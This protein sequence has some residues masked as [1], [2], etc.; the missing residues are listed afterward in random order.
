MVLHNRYDT[1]IV[2]HNYPSLILSKIL[3]KNHPELLMIDDE[4]INTADDWAQ[5]L[6]LLD[7]KLLKKLGEYYELAPLKN[8]DQYIVIKPWY[9]KLGANTI[10]L[11]ADGL[12]NLREIQRKLNLEKLPIDNFD[13]IYNDYC[14]RIVND[15][16]NLKVLKNWDLVLSTTP[17]DESMGKIIL[18]LEKLV[19]FTESSAAISY[20]L[21]SIYH[22]YV[23]NNLS[24][25]QKRF[26]SLRLLS[27]RYVLDSHQ[28]TK[29]LDLVC[30]HSV[31]ESIIKNWQFK[32]NE[33]SVLLESYEGLVKSKT[34]L[35]VG[36]F[37]KELPFLFKVDSTLYTSCLLKVKS[38]QHIFTSFVGNEF[39][40]TSENYLGRKIPFFKIYF[41]K[42]N[43]VQ[44]N[45]PLVK[46]PG[47]K[48]NFNWEE[49][50]RLILYELKQFIP[51]LAADQFTYDLS[52]SKESHLEFV[53]FSLNKALPYNIGELNFGELMETPAP[54]KMSKLKDLD[55]WGQFRGNYLGF[56]S[57]L[58]E[59]RLNF[60]R[61][62]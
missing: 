10:K 48:L 31:K 8:L 32:T 43:E 54:L 44:I 40:V 21:Q 60:D 28:I 29:D 39:Y 2:G 61:Q 6:S 36:E 18:Q 3:I 52:H 33:K 50:N 27:P 47:D 20:L 9:L 11:G 30:G 59:A 57:Y 56:F 37:N 16:W 49:I 45:F 4:R 19:S 46:I 13:Q 7:I 55:Y 25:T 23:T 41:A 22:R 12:E 62:K 38:T 51:H 24:E 53:D 34:I 1:I 26:L 42:N 5:E 15:I 14:D 17:V 58:I 35:F